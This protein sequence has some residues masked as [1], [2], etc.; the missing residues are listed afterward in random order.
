MNSELSLC[1][2]SHFSCF[3]LYTFIYI[4]LLLLLLL[5]F[6]LEMLRTFH[7]FNSSSSFIESLS[8]ATKN[9]IQNWTQHKKKTPNGKIL[10]NTS[11]T[12]T[13]LIGPIN[14]GCGG[15]REGSGWAFVKAWEGKRNFKVKSESLKK[16]KIIVWIFIFKTLHTHTHTH[17]DVVLHL[18]KEKE[19]CW[20]EK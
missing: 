6:L 20:K 12:I 5:R 1:F 15:C 7:S 16:Y 4:L 2:L 13:L 3:F 14:H 11:S 17:I 10:L 19:L 8:R 18:F 9:K